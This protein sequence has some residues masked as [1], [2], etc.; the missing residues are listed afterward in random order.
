MAV[1]FDLSRDE[2]FLG[3]LKNYPDIT[4]SEI[5]SQIVPIGRRLTSL[6]KQ[7]LST[8]K[9]GRL[10]RVRGS[11]RRYRASAEGESPASV[12]G[13]LKKGIVG[14]KEGRLK[15]RIVSKAPQTNIL[16][17]AGRPIFEGVAERHT[18]G[19]VFALISNLERKW[20]ST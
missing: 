17:N 20:A 9:S 10:Y 11:G 5:A 12:T 14:H 15:Y 13:R 7:N 4:K 3:A 18:D 16:V 19:L 6:V 8:A 2:R 1:S